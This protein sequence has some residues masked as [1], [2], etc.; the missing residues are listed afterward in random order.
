MSSYAFASLAHVRILLL[1]VGPI[2][3]ATFEAYAA[4][5]RTFDS[6]RLGDIPG[7]AKDE[8]ARFMPSPLSSGY[9][10]LSFPSHPSSPSHLPLSLFRPSHFNLGVIG[11]AACS[12]AYSL[13]TAL[14]Q[15]ENTLIEISPESSTFPLA[16]TCFAFQDDEGANVSLGENPPGLSMIPNVMGNKKLYIGTLLADLC[17]QI[18]SEFGRVVH[19]LETPIG[20]E[21]LNASLF[22]TLPAAAEMPFALESN[23]HLFQSSFTSHSSQPEL[24]SSSLSLPSNYG[25]KRNSSA[26]PGVGTLHRQSTLGP[27][28]TK[29]R[30]SAVGTASSH[31]RLYKVYG[32]FF[33]LAGRTQD[34]KIW[35]Q[36]ALNLFKTG[37]DPVWQASA[38]EAMAVM[39][40]LESWAAGQGLQ[41]SIS[42]MKEPWMEIYDLLSQAISIYLK[43]SVPS[44]SSQDY[45]LL[46]FVYT[47]AVLRQTSLLFCVWS[48]KGWGALAF[49]SMLQPGATSYL[50]K[51]ISDNSWANLERLSAITGI[52]RAQIANTITQAHGPWLL[53]LGPH[54][55][56]VVLQSMASIY[57]C[58]GFKR[59]EVY[60][61]RE[62][63]SCIM[64]LVVCGRDED[65][66]LRKSDL[67][68]AGLVIRTSGL[69][70]GDAAV[71][72]PAKGSV[73]MR[74][75]ENLEGNQSI[76]KLLVYACKVLGVNLEAVSLASSA[77]GA[78]DGDMQPEDVDLVE[79]L[80]NTFGWPELQV[81]VV[82]E[83]IAVAE[84]LP[85]QLAVAR[86]SLSALKTMNS[87]LAANDQYHL[88]QTASRALAVTRRRGDTST[89]EY[90]AGRPILSIA[91]LPLPL[92]RLPIEKPMSLLASST[93]S[94]AAANLISGGV[95]DPF[96]YNPR[97]S[98][99]AQGKSVI[100]QGEVVELVITL[101]NPFV[102][103]LELQSVSLIT[104]GVPFECSSISSIIIPPNSLYPITLSGIAKSPGTLH[105]KGCTVQAPN[106]APRD[107]L[108]PVSS[109]ADEDR[110]TRRQSMI[111]CESGRTKH[112]GLDARVWE[113]AGKV[114]GI[115]ATKGKG[116]KEREGRFLQC[117]VVPEQPLLRIR[118]TSLTHAAVM[119]YNG[120]KST[121]RL[122]L[123]NVSAV[124]IDFLRL[125]FDDSTITPA[126]EALSEGQLSVFE[127]YETEYN[128]IHRQAFSWHR[129]KEV[130]VINPGQKIVLSVTCLGKVGCTSGAVHVSYSYVHRNEPSTS[131]GEE[132]AV[133]P[134]IFHTRQLTYPVTVTVY[135]ILECHD[136]NIMPLDTLNTPASSSNFPYSLA[137]GQGDAHEWCLFSVEVRNTYGLPFEVTF[138]RVQ[139]GTPDAT[140]SSIVPPGSMSRYV[141]RSFIH[142]TPTNQTPSSLF[143]TS[144]IIPIKRFRLPESA[145]SRP[146]PTLSDRQFVVSKS[147]LSASED[148]AQRELF[149]YR[150]ELLRIVSGR[151][152]EAN[153]SRSGDLS[154]RQQRMTLHMLK[155]L[156]TDIVRIDLSFVHYDPDDDSPAPVTLERRWGRYVVRPN[157]IVYV[158]VGVVNSGPS[159]L[160]TTLTLLPSP[161]DHV[162]SQGTLSGIPLGRI[163]SGESKVMEVPVC[164]L[165]TGTFEVGAEVR[166]LG[167]REEGL[168]DMERDG[169]RVGVGRVRALVREDG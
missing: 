3:R 21:Y 94:A 13:A 151:W 114:L 34:A 48:S 159:P 105:I 64:D 72:S 38:V 113:K 142:F 45:S 80:N 158:R 90:W 136:M 61:L 89:V 52:T 7:D 68:S 24:A 125:S 135:H 37:M 86:F 106:G 71:N 166:M 84:A 8:R 79:S 108:L 163:G 164:F 63:I 167:S 97:K 23:P 165:C 143:Q 5:I 50:Q 134:Q 73:G 32:D 16:K 78:S 41:T 104:I 140:A 117:A 155:A 81:G 25:M 42:D 57:S 9:L 96:L 12:S 82:R 145:I 133:T 62:V 76:L 154:L 53:H 95:T 47:T 85:D 18:L 168:V 14:E 6:I 122:T 156:R 119:L 102:F 98:M 157:G 124:P 169:G 144:I 83:A 137:P 161:S 112:A 100:V 129:D 30:A 116:E 110:Q 29:K 35:Y 46:A 39:T 91:V 150:E 1:P 109:D 55:R 20:N 36:E 147:T 43:A 10:H 4:E 111:K 153:G 118:W 139:E 132:D 141:C 131:E 128:L 19:V 31:G 107:F 49:A 22:P 77:E 51:I 59:K 160:T 149:W 56:L 93:S 54:E 162:L 2:P 26:S 58:L 152:K 65:D 115:G 121:I 123:E 40:M 146:I 127:T 28:P 126:Q 33:L 17:S 148:K 69:E 15:F 27:L 87:I 99:N 66:Q 75:K 67:G 120:E 138:E 103:E 101:R 74:R 44:E 60:I 11:I 70:N 92:H 130:K 88:Y